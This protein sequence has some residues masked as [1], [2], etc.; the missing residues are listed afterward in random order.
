[1]QVRV[2]IVQPTAVGARHVAAGHA[3]A[4]GKQRSVTPHVVALEHAT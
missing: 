2:A 4:L 1:M 3:G